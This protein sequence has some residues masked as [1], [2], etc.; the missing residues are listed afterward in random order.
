MTFTID[1]DFSFQTVGAA[2]GRKDRGAAANDTGETFARTLM[3]AGEN[4]EDAPIP[5]PRRKDATS[6]QTVAIIP[7]LQPDA[8]PDPN[9]AAGADGTSPAAPEPDVAL[10]LA[11][12]SPEEGSPPMDVM[13]A[14]AETLTRTPVPATPATGENTAPPETPEITAEA[15]DAEAADTVT[16]DSEPTP[17]ETPF[18]SPVTAP[19]PVRQKTAQTSDPTVSDAVQPDVQ[20]VVAGPIAPVTIPVTVRDGTKVSTD[21]AS[22]GTSAAESET[23]VPFQAQSGKPSAKQA[24]PSDIGFELAMSEERASSSDATPKAVGSHDAGKAT[25]T[26]GVSP[27]PDPALMGAVQSTPAPQ[28]APAPATAANAMTPTHGI[29]TA[30]PAETV[31]IITDSIE[32]ADDRKDRITVQLDPPELGRVSIDFKFD[33]RGLQHVTI[34]GDNPEALRQLRLM[35]FELSQALERNGLSSE[36]MTFQ[37]HAHSG[38][39]QNSQPGTPARSSIAALAG[40][41]FVSKSSAPPAQAAR[42]APVAGS[43]LDIR[44]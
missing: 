31:R 11:A 18:A 6:E 13:M 20:V 16:H 34:T 30:G 41:D 15:T 7:L 14:D 43:G 4:P 5:D 38:Q 29:I 32:T 19:H 28:P 23:P 26:T 44:V 24:K 25:G 3:R 22:V 27:A 17:P 33:S 21:I 10:E 35:H 8:Q 2:A 39:Q 42:P 9:L 40:D 37:Q 1:P 12:D 36:N